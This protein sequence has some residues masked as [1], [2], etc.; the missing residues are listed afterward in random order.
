MVHANY[1][2]N[3]VKHTEMLSTG[4]QCWPLPGKKLE[5]Y[6]KATMYNAHV[7]Y[8]R[9]Y[10]YVSY[11]L[12]SNKKLEHEISQNFISNQELPHVQ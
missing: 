11:T 5:E 2:R 6:S 8:I 10:Y 7:Y 12:P 3:M 9:I 1:P 4:S